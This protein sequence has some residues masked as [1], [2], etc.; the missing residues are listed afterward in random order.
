MGQE[1]VSSRPAAQ[2]CGQ[3]SLPRAGQARLDLLVSQIE[4]F[5]IGGYTSS[6]H[7]SMARLDLYVKVEIDLT[8]GEKPQ[9]LASE[10]VRMLRKLYGVR[11]AEVTNFE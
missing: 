4:H 10:I 11:D 3:I 8:E 7:R 9:K 1:M 2:H 5:S 6:Y